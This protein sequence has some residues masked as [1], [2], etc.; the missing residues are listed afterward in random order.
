MVLL[1]QRTFVAGYL[2][3]FL[4]QWES[5]TE[6][7]VTLDAVTGFMNPFSELNPCRVPTQQKLISLDNDP[8]LDQSIEI[9]KLKDA[10]IVPIISSGFYS[11]DFTVLKLERGV[12]YRKRFIINLKVSFIS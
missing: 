10:V 3:K 1:V 5:I 7:L 2:P 4:S 11:R 6:D 9:L 8:V 12:E